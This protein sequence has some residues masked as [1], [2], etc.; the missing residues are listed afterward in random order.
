M[1]DAQVIADA[2]A[3]L[4]PSGQATQKE[5]DHARACEHLAL[6]RS[7]IDDLDGSRFVR[8]YC[9]SCRVVALMPAGGGGEP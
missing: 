7:M 5:I 9:P 6:R 1:S 2:V 3:T 4:A 8:L